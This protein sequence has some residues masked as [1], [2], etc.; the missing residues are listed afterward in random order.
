MSKIKVIFDKSTKSGF[1]PGDSAMLEPGHAAEVVKSGDAHY[2][3]PPA[4]PKAKAKAKK[5]K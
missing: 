4:K 5:E 2:D 1:N 3:K